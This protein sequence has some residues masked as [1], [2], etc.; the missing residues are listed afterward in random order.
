MIRQ[1]NITDSAINNTEIRK[2]HCLFNSTLTFNT[3]VNVALLAPYHCDIF[4]I[5][6]EYIN[7]NV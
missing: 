6:G 7:K 3:N 1:S 2:L 4:I 5:S